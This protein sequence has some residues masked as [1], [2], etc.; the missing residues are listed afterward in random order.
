[1]LVRPHLSRLYRLAYR[2]TG[3]RENAEDLVQS[4]LVRLLRQDARLAE[5]ESLGPWLARALYHLYVDDVRR[6]SRSP[7]LL[8]SDSVDD[9]TLSAIPDDSAETPEQSSER[10]LIRRRLIAALAQLTPEQRALI[11]WHDMEGYTLDELATVL[12]VPVGTLK[13]RLHR[14]RAQLRR[15]LAEP[16]AAPERVYA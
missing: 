8:R 9:E 7:T 12:D 6:G 11:A 16:S 13:S 1:V 15:L 4:L 2:L 10:R 5:V 3:S 14:G